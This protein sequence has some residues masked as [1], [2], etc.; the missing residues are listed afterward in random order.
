MRR[1]TELTSFKIEKDT[2]TIAIDIMAVLTNG[3]LIATANARQLMSS[4]CKLLRQRANDT[5]GYKRNQALATPA[6]PH[7]VPTTKPAGMT[8]AARTIFQVIKRRCPTA[9]RR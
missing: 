3:A 4:T 7:R 5:T 1:D 6:S 2:I 9:R 8:M